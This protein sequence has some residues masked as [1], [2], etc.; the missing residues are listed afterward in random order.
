MDLNFDK[1]SV[2]IE[3]CVDKFSVTKMDLNFDMTIERRFDK[4]RMT[5]EKRF[6][7]FSVTVGS[8]QWIVRS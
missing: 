4:L 7:K 8:D 3:K 1:R 6:D 2:T 5:I